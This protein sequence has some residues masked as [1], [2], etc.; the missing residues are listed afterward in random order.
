[1]AENIGAVRLRK[2]L[3]DKGHT[4][5]WLADKIGT[6]QTNVS[7]WMLG[8]PVPLDMALAIRKVTGIEIEAWV[9]PAA[10]RAAS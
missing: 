4:Q 6:H 10:H 5:K 3:A 7:A 1:M 8:R 9:A 2:W